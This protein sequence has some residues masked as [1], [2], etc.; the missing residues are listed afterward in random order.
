[1]GPGQLLIVDDHP[2]VLQ[3][4]RQLAEAAGIAVL[5]E[6]RDVVS[7]YRSF[8]KHRPGLVVT[9]LGFGDDGLSGLSLIRRVRA[10]EPATR[11]LA[12]SMH[13][14]P[15]IVSR[16]LESG[17][18]GYVLKDARGPDFVEALT[19]VRAGEVYLDHRLATEV[20][21]LNAGARP[22]PLARLNARELQILSLLS[23]GRSYDSIADSLS[24]SYR[25]VVNAGSS[26]RRKLGAGSLAE[27]IQIALAHDDVSS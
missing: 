11:I 17:A 19:R 14:D 7:G 20:A 2:V 10:L 4:F 24:L 21:M 22:A 26:M 5:H 12:F 27:L 25:T 8:H 3:G 23:R 15:V 13:D 1:M 9:D 16:A 18:L 6:A